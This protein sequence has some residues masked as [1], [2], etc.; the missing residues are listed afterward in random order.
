MLLPDG[1]E[2]LVSKE[3]DAPVLEFEEPKVENWAYVS[4]NTSKILREW[5]CWPYLKLKLEGCPRNYVMKVVGIVKVR[6]VDLE[7]WMEIP[8]VVTP[9]AKKEEKGIIYK[10]NSFIASSYLQDKI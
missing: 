10:V 1:L 8:L 7:R 4:E 3:V 9:I 6:L 2:A 5:R